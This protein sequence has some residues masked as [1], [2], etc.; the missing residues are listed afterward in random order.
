MEALFWRIIRVQICSVI[1]GFAKPCF[2]Q[3]SALSWNRNPHVLYIR[4]GSNSTLVL[5]YD[6]IPGF[7]KLSN[8]LDS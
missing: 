4:S 6:K 7:A 2:R 8:S 5:N 3:I 1:E